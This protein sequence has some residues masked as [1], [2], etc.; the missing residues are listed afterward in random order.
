MIFYLGKL[1]NRVEALV[2]STGKRAKTSTHLNV[3]VYLK[4]C[5]MF[6]T[7]LHFIQFLFLG[8]CNPIIKII[9]DLD[10]LRQKH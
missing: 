3:C 2:E 8:Q 10:L 5:E 7:K 6:T 4:V 9:S 1:R